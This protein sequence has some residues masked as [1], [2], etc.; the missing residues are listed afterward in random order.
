MAQQKTGTRAVQNAASWARGEARK[1]ANA[2]ANEAR[3][4]ANRLLR[5]Q[6]LPTPHEVQ[7]AK[8]KAIR[9]AAREAGTLAPIGMTQAAFNKIPREGTA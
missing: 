2:A 4:A 5:A 7:K 8:R 1:K 9:D 3:A 6:G